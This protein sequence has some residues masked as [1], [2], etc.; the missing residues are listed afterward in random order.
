MERAIVGERGQITLPKETVS[1]VI[2]ELFYKKHFSLVVSELVR[3]EAIK[4]VS[5]KKPANI[6]F[7]EKRLEQ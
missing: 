4:N 5:L 6:D 7:L 3:L 1:G 2:V